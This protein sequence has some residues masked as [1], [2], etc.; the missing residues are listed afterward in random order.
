MKEF[1]LRLL[2]FGTQKPQGPTTAPARNGRL[3]FLLVSLWSGL[4]SQAAWAGGG[5][6]ANTFDLLQQYLGYASGGDGS[7]AYRRTTRAMG[8]KAILDARDAGF[9]FLRISMSGYSPVLHNG[10]RNDV[11]PVWRSDPATFWQAVDAMFDDLDKAGLAV[12][13]TLLWNPLQ[14]PALAGDTEADL[15]GRPES[16]SRQL[17]LQF[18]SDVARRYRGRRT[19]LFY[20]LT[21]EFNL[22]TDLDMVRRCRKD[23]GDAAPRCAPVGNFSSADLQAFARDMLATLRQFDPDRPVSSGYG[24]PKKSDGHLARQPEWSPN[25]ADWTVD[26]QSDYLSGLM[27]AQRDFDIVSAH[28]YPQSQFPNSLSG[29]ALMT[30]LADLAH[31]RHKR[32][33]VGEFG[34]RNPSSFVA[35]LVTAFDSGGA[36][37]AALWAWEFHQFTTFTPRGGAPT[38]FSVEP[39]SR[40]DVMSVLAARRNGQRA[41]ANAAHADGEPR[42]VLT[43]PL[44]CAILDRPTT[45]AV[46]AS[47]GLGTPQRVAFL[48][49]GQVIGEASTPPFLLDFDPNSVPAGA[50]VLEAR[51]MGKFGAVAS[52]RIPVMLRGSQVGCTVP[53]D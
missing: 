17:A 29:A 27:E 33:F 25:G 12:V 30:G 51:A 47:E 26:S 40:P 39:G 20:E 52:D 19:I 4:L 34:D 45:L 22:D 37:D 18:V 21:N 16:A 2:G 41:P 49:N 50:G 35:D 53:N 28:I 42:V 43:W 1:L 8:R 46:S 38:A 5:L 3:L 31:A 14:F 32:L 24:L 15:I 13:P 10:P 9:T 44:S 11:L 48:L 7:A 36:D 23:R 6:G